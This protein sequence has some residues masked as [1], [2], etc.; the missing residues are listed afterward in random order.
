MRVLVISD[1]HANLEALEACMAAAPEHDWS[2]NLGDI[3]GYGASPNEVTEK[4]RQISRQFVRGNHDKACTRLMDLRDF[5]PIAAAAAVWTGETLSP[6]HLEFLRALPA[7]PVELMLQDA[8]PDP[9]GARPAAHSVSHSAAHSD[10]PLLVHGSTL[11]EDEYVI[12]AAEAM[13][14]LGRSSVRLTFFGHTHIQGGFS[15]AQDGASHSFRPSFGNRNERQQVTMRLEPGIRYMINPG[16]VGQ[17]RDGDWRAAFLLYDSDPGEIT[18]Y[19]LPYNIERAQQ[20]IFD[21]HLPPRLATRL[22]E[23]R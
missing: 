16:S 20:K 10:V 4:A 19:R 2:V 11:D 17:P 5:N 8:A 23:G 1:I 13:D 6:P 7:G 12:T 21:A 3:V 14:V 15:M 18:F 9:P 22:A